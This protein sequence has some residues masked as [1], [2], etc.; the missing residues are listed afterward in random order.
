MKGQEVLLKS[1]KIGLTKSKLVS[2]LLLL[3]TVSISENASAKNLDISIFPA[4]GDIP[5]ELVISTKVFEAIAL[6]SEALKTKNAKIEDYEK[7][8]FSFGTD[9]ITV[10]FIPSSTTSDN[11]YSYEVSLRRDT[12]GVISIHK[13]I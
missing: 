8:S 5:A 13:G 6:A 11:L 9:T 7:I 1:S 3:L 2:A 12:L 4:Q 10:A